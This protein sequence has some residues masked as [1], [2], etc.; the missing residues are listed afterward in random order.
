[1]N[2]TARPRRSDATKE[3]IRTAAR[4][5]FAS[6]GYER[7]T[8][9]SIAADAG[10][11]PAMVMRYFGTKERLFA[12]AAAVDLRL[13][14]LGAVPRECLGVTLAAH[15]LDR[16]EGDDTLVALL[17]AAL[18]HP[19]AAE[20]TREM[21]AGQVQARVA[22][23]VAD[24]GEAAVRAGLIATQVLGAALCRYVLAVPPVVAMPAADL[25]AWLGGTL[26]RYLTG[27][28]PVG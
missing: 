22:E 18:T 4:E 15:F 28:P 11:D 16:W 9:R 27:P 23:I 19:T 14:G 24:P 8:I 3:A 12:V 5:R 10:I 21:F 2:S 6:D 1:M 13:P 20:R 25:V 17:R 7:A 26:Q